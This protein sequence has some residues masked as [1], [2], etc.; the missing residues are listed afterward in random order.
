MLIWLVFESKRNH[1]MVLDPLINLKPFSNR[2]L[3]GLF[4]NLYFYECTVWLTCLPYLFNRC[5]ISLLLKES[6]ANLDTCSAGWMSVAYRS[7]DPALQKAGQGFCMDAPENAR[8]NHSEADAC[9]IRRWVWG[10]DWAHCA[11][12]QQ[13]SSIWGRAHIY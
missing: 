11:V 5:N 7:T 2:I 10:L 13:E 4:W 12:G 8:A 3:K 6:L 1:K 9:K